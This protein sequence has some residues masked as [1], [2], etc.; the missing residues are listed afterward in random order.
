[1]KIVRESLFEAFREDSDP[2]EDM[3]IG[4]LPLIKKWI[5]AQFHKTWPMFINC[6]NDRTHSVRAD[7]SKIIINDDL[8]IDVLASVDVSGEF[9]KILPEYIK[10]NYVQCDFVCSFPRNGYEKYL[11]NQVD[12]QLRFYMN[13]YPAD[14]EA[15]KENIKKYCVVNN[16]E[17]RN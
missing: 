6:K 11:P 12:G 15:E 9:G 4:T 1:M 8:S 3:G 16:I 7:S 5:D 2:I 13:P 14:V 10:F 17:I